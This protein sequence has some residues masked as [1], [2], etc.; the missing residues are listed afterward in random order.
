MTLTMNTSTLTSAPT[1]TAAMLIRRP[2]AEVFAA[3]VDP[4]ITSKF[5]F[6]QGSG[7][8][9]PGKRVQWDWE[10]YNV[11]IQVDVKE[12]EPNR[13]LLIEWLGYG[14]PTM[15]EWIFSDRS[16]GTT[17]VEVTEAGFRGDA[18]ELVKQAIASTGGFTLVLAG[19]KALLEHDIKL[20]LV[21]DRFPDS[22][23]LDHELQDLTS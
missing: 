3:F 14:S 18:D 2:V 16:D 5:W 15:V 10:M 6:T 8:L 12:F 23:R 20:N 11:S 1:G 9:E 7:K 19:L 4:E 17:F 21:P 13:R 22:K